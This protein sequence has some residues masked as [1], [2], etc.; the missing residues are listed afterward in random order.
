MFVTFDSMFGSSSV[1]PF[2]KWQSVP[3]IIGYVTGTDH[4]CNRCP[5]KVWW[6]ITILTQIYKSMEMKGLT[7][8]GAGLKVNF[9]H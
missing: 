2:C 5:A 8:M 1:L 4:L 3:M 6:N 9:D 7:L